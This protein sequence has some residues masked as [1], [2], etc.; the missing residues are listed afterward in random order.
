MDLACPFFGISL[1]NLSLVALSE[2][3]LKVLT[4]AKFICSPRHFS[5]QL[6]NADFILFPTR[7]QSGKTGK[8]TRLGSTASASSLAVK[9]LKAVLLPISQLLQTI[10]RTQRK[11]GTSLS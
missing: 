3:F 10:I 8:N 5:H 1:L 11:Q 6:E 2:R 7:G 4:R 9:V